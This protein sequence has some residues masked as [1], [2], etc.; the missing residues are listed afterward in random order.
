MEAIINLSLSVVTNDATQATTTWT[1]QADQHTAQNE[2]GTKASNGNN[3]ASNTKAIYTSPTSA[4]GTSL[5]ST[6][7]HPAPQQKK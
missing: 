7:P 3:A 2:R 1:D 6:T 4:P 5:F